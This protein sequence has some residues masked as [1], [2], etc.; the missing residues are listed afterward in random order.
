MSI[1]LA[2]ELHLGLLQVRDADVGPSE[3]EQL[4]HTRSSKR[5][6]REQGAVGLAG[7]GDRLL[8]LAL[9]EQPS[10]HGWER[11]G[12]SGKIEGGTSVRSNVPVVEAINGE[13][14]LPEG[15]REALGD[16]FGAA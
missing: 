14:V 8:E 16:L 3:C 12:R 2:C 15:G 13:G 5:G 11:D 9:L 6:Q 10:L 4:G 7:G 1:D